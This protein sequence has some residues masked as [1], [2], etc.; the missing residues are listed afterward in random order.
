MTAKINVSDF[1][2]EAT[3]DC[4]QAFRW[5]HADDGWFVGVVGREVWRLRQQGSAL[6]WKQ[7]NANKRKLNDNSP[8]LDP[9]PQTTGERKGPSP[10]KGEV[11]P[12]QAAPEAI[13][14]SGEGDVPSAIVR[15][16]AL[17]ISLRDIAATFPADDK[18]LHAALRKHWGLRV[19]RQEP[20]E[21]L[22]S[23]IASSAKQIVQI[24][25]IV[26]LLAYR[27]GEP[28]GNGFH[29]FPTVEVIAR[30]SHKQLRACKLGFRAKYLLAT[31]RMIDCGTVKLDALQSMEYERALE[32][33]LKL[34]GVGE[35]IANCVLLFSC[36][37]DQA[38]PIDVWIER[39][40]RRLYFCENTWG[41]LHPREIALKKRSH[42]EVTRRQ[43]RE[44]TRSHF[45]PCAGWA[46]QYLFF[47]ERT[48]N[49]DVRKQ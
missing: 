30:T 45:G 4:G 46:Q 44:F 19:A 32:E 21:C 6:E 41:G 31:A 9:L 13:R 10:L 39:A 35:K 3:L 33:L 15:Y 12:P 48:R 23:F 8:H 26:E 5:L 25:Q 11:Y 47:A 38:F 42:K 22:A 17:D 27:F 16:L 34:P 28:I 36:G 14:G 24:R 29:A 20:W 18:P 43:L 49:K 2:L 40:L 37:F 7:R 1:S